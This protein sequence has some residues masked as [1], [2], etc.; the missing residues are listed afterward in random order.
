MALSPNIGDISITN[1]HTT[2][3]ITDT[4]GVYNVTTNPGGWEA[5]NIAG[6]D[7]VTATLTLTFNGG[8]AQ[9]VDVTSQIPATVTGDIVFNDITI[10]DY[11]DGKATII[12]TIT[13]ASTTYTKTL[14]MLFTCEAREAI[15]A[16]WA[17]IAG[18][19]CGNSCSI[20]DLIEDANTAEGLLRALKSAGACCN[21]TTCIDK[22]LETINRFTEFD[23]CSCGC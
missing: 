10:A 17:N 9:V 12:Y 23:D 15:D 2:I 3:S 7:V 16:L 8:T 13:T 5:P 18:K 22:L 6:S 19:F 20:K 14:N 1:S 4:T 21:D 11:A